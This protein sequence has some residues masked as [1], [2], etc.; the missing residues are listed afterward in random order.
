M[1][2]NFS[3]IPLTKLYK[4]WY[5]LF[6][7]ALLLSFVVL[8][9]TNS[10]F[11]IETE[12]KLLDYRFR[13]DPIPEKADSNI[14]LVVIDDSSL[15]YFAKYGISWPWPRTFHGYALDYFS[16]AGSK[17]V[18]FDILFYEPDIEREETFAE[19]TDGYFAE[20]I[21]ECGNVYLGAQLRRDELKSAPEIARSA[22]KLSGEYPFKH[23]YEGLRSPIETFLQTNCKI[24]LVDAFPDPDGVIRRIPALG[25]VNDTVLPQMA[26]KVWLD[27]V[28]RSDSIYAKSKKLIVENEQIPLD[29]DGNYLIN[30]YG[31]Y[32]K[33]Q[34][35]TAYPFRAVISSASALKQGLQ[36]TILLSAFQDKFVIIGVTAAGLF[37]LK[38]SPY[39][40]IM[41]GMQIW[42]TL[43]SNY[44]NQDFIRPLPP[45][46]NFIITFIIIFCVV[47]L[48]TNLP[49]RQANLIV[50][51]MLATIFLLNIIL[52]K[53]D[54]ILMNLLMPV[55]GF[56]LAYL[57]INTISYLL[58]G[59]SKR[60]IRKLFSRYLDEN[61]ILQ[62]EENP[63][64]IKLGGEEI[65]ATV[66]Y[67]DIYDFTTISENIAPSQL[68]TDLN[69]Y[70]E[71]L[72]EFIFRYDGLLDKYTGDGIMAL[73]GAPIERSDHAL[74][75]CRSA[76]AHRLYRKELSYKTDLTLMERFHLGTRTG[77]NSGLLVAGNIGGETRMD[78]TAIGDTVN[79]AARLESVNKIFRTNI[80][81][82]ESTHDLVKEEFVCRELD[83]LKVKGRNQPT[84]IFELICSRTE[85]PD[86]R[87]QDR[88]GKYETALNLYRSGNWQQA[89]EI[90]AELRKDPFNDP[91]SEVLLTRCRYLLESPPKDWDGVIK[92]EVK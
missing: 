45:I 15:D 66:L 68:V 83:S 33:D 44:I 49:A 58:E 69:L 89:A 11:L 56:L 71:K 10:Q 8:W 13:F 74:L 48:I 61:V 54:R 34:P 79:T 86:Q 90:F 59:R 53:T 6:L 5:F 51:S 31:E 78:Y 14:V 29:E 28:A 41:P 72:I 4:K 22:V 91:A 16:Q 26:L 70:F 24:G 37:D 46:I 84:N 17:A 88:I 82:S 20:T 25:K 65:A 32:E 42:A 73:F 2:F 35:F 75:A 19:E 85:G 81:I 18:V 27:L 1:N 80:I 40:K 43:L 77:I 23:N 62:L 21:A 30:W 38:T 55:I 50:F 39:D 3:I 76:N 63:E 52:W 92:L 36:P 60:Q 57:I 67:T 47:F 87:T 9:F 12:L 7:F 64:Q